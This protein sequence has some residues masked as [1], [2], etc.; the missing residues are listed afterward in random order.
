MNDL[1]FAFRRLRK[2]AGFTTVALLT[3]A[4]CIGANVAI[5][6]VVDSVLLRRMPVP[7]PDRLVTTVNSY[8]KAGVVRAGASLPNY[9]DRKSLIGSFA[10]TAAVRSGTVI[11]GEAGSPTRV[12]VERV[13]PDFFATLGVPVWLGRSFTEEELE[14]SR[15]GVAILTEP[16]WRAHFQADPNVIGRE[17]RVDGLKVTVVGVLPKGF[18][19]LSSE[20]Q[21]YFPL[22]SGADERTVERRHSNGLQVIA[23]LKPGAT[24]GQAQ[25]QVDTLNEHQLANDPYSQLIKDAGYRT[26]VT[27][28]HADHVQ[29]IRTTLLLLQGGAL[30]LLLIGGVNLVNLFLIRAGARSKEFAVRQAL[31]AQRLSVARDLFSETLLV[32]LAGGVAGLV[33]G[34]AGIQALTF[35][36]ADRL[37][38]GAE[39]SFNARVA[40]VTLG[41]AALAG[42][43]LGLPMIWLTMHGRLSAALQTESRGGTAS[44]AA[45]GLRHTL[46]V[47]Q[48]ALAFMLLT[49]AGLLG[50]SL[51]KVLAESPGFVP[52]HLLTGQIV[53]PWNNYRDTPPR[54]TFIERLLTELRAQPG[55]KSA[56]VCTL[57][58]MSQNGDQ[59]ATTVEGYVLGPGEALQAHHSAGVAGDYWGA[60]GIPLRAGRLHEE[61]DFRRE[62][63]ICWVDEDFA[64]RYWPKGDAI[65]RRVCNGPVFKAEE[66]FTVVGVV[67]RVKHRELGNKSDQGAVYYPYRYYSPPGFYLSVRTSVEPTAFAATLRQVVLR[68]DPELPVD[69]LRPMQARIEESLI[70]R[71]SP[72]L[73]AGIFAGVALL[74]ASVGTYG[75]LA[76]AISQ[77]TREIGVRMALGALPSQIRAQFLALGARL[78]MPG[79]ALGALGAWGASRAMRSVLFEVNAMHLGV[80]ALTAMVMILVVLLATFL[81]SHR[82]SRVSPTEALRAD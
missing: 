71:R 75:V 76:Y 82:G 64:K 44:R 73:L 5:F 45:Q 69:D 37:P 61:A 11:I 47:G 26:Y 81:P 1:K 78:L 13:T 33:L 23:R 39:I 74:L 2:N 80:L 49:G 20:A 7:E 22:A 79:L 40:L 21:L 24:L 43:M 59:N 68:L 42:L 18:R 4:L 36:G 6:A 12:P 66:A 62:Q 53:L 58:P 32:A 16:Y 56:G 57:M 65:G 52:D 15:S 41:G 55:V 51:Q 46:I 28:L 77:R 63:R 3:L 27:P 14:Y 48:V 34:F 35:L 9:Y 8:P 72:A 29:Q 54:L 67:G 10:K 70:P 50:L 25:A 19:Y 38:L 31:G 60:T 30:A 17:M